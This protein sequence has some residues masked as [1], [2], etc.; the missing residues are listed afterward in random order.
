MVPPKLAKVSGDAGGL[1]LL[2]GIPSN[3]DSKQFGF[4]AHGFKT[5]SI[6]FLIPSKGFFIPS[7][8]YLILRT[9]FSSN[10]KHTWDQKLESVAFKL[11]VNTIEYSYNSNFY[12]DAQLA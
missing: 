11:G 1:R 10:S 5:P 2:C 4:G 8:W 12:E 9:R 6:G 7:K 3:F